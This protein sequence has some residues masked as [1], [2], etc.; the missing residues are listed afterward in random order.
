[1]VKA[2]S[3]LAEESEVK[4]EFGFVKSEEP[5]AKVGMTCPSGHALEPHIAS[6]ERLC[7]GCG[8][9]FPAG[10]TASGCEMCD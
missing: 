10:A 6:Q 2:V 4:E 3:P 8:R 7:D 5:E 1:M 9:T